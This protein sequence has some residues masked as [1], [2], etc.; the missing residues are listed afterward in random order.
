MKVRA[1]VGTLALLGLMNVEVV[2]KPTTA[3]ILLHSETGCLGGCI[4][5]PQSRL[6]ESDKT[7][8]S[9][10][11]WHEVGLDVLIDRVKGN[12]VIRRVCIQ[13]II[14]ERFT[15]DVLKIVTS[16]KDRGVRK[17]ISVST[18]PVGRE[19]LHQLKDLGV[20][21]LGVGFDAA[22]PEAFKLVNKPFSWDYYLEFLN[23]CMDVFGPGKV[24]VHLIYGL[25]ED[26]AEFLNSMKFFKKLGANISLFSFTPVRGTLCENWKRPSIRGYRKM[27][28]LKYLMDLGFD[29][30]DYITLRNGKVCLDRGLVMEILEKL[31]TYHRAFITS[32]CPDCNRPFYNESVRGPYYNYPSEDFLLKD[33]E[34]LIDELK[35]LLI[36]CE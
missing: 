4:F 8:V 14:K 18:T 2:E 9:R 12:S 30:S 32:G 20:D 24:Y 3:Y 6:S 35:E 11:S 1:S 31:D 16:F 27:Q 17:P 22:T 28:I 19:F 33:R 23:T 7:L 15:D 25:G 21:A 34:R 29:V 10:V 13:T 26:E 5:C 36:D